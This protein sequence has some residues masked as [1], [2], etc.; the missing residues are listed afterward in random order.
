MSLL[1]ELTEDLQED[2]DALPLIEM[3]DESVRALQKAKGTRGGVRNLQLQKKG[4]IVKRSG[5]K[6]LFK[7]HPDVVAGA[8]TVALNGLNKHNKWLRDTIKLHAKA[9]Y[10]R[11]MMTTIVDALKNSGKFKI[12]RV[13]FEKGGKTWIMRKR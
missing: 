11:K 1:Q 7:T 5:V 9:D 6:D 3:L 8:A 10:E 12:W 4:Q 13:K 2:V